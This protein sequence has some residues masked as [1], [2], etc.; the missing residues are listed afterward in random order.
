MT[1]SDVTIGSYYYFKFLNTWSSDFSG[2]YKV[3]GFVSPDIVDSLNSSNNLFKIFFDDYGLDSDSYDGYIDRNTLVF[4]AT[5]LV[6]TDPIEESTEDVTVYIPCTLVDFSNSH[7]YLKANR[8]I[9]S[10]TSSPR[11]IDT[12]LEMNNF[13]TDT[14]KVIRDAIKSTAEFVADDLSF[15]ISETDALVTQ[16]EY[17]EFEKTREKVYTDQQNALIQSNINRETAERRL[18]TTTAEMKTAYNKYIKQ[19]NNLTDQLKNIQSVAD[20]NDKINATLN[21]VVAEIKDIL[22]YIM[23]IN[24]TAFDSVS[25]LPANYTAEQLYNRIVE[26]VE[27]KS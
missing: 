15:E 6:T 27:S 17:D 5:R 2:S 16:S 13:K 22:A 23:T 20:A 1:K 3:T 25:D 7:A 10:I 4:T 8:L 12:E 14:K 21:N 26:I 24:P 11:V 9:Y 18:Y 19:L